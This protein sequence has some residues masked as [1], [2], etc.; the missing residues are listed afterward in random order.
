MVSVEDGSQAHATGVAAGDLVAK[1]RS[2]G[3]KLVDARLFLWR[4]RFYK[5]W[6]TSVCSCFVR[7][8]HG[9]DGPG[10]KVEVGPLPVP[11]E[12]CR[13]AGLWRPL[14]PVRE[15]RPPVAATSPLEGPNFTVRVAET[16]VLMP[17]S[18]ILPMQ[19]APLPTMP[20]LNRNTNSFNRYCP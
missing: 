8:N 19:F 9:A 1:H 7:E 2:R 5:A 11:A 13:T 16:S 14:G 15:D 3:A 6:S 12:R 18:A 4:L 10:G 17:P 20:F